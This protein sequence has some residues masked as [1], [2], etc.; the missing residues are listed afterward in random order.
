[1]HF[2]LCHSLWM[3]WCV[4]KVVYASCEVCCLCCSSI[5]CKQHISFNTFVFTTAHLRPI[6]WLAIIKHAVRNL[7]ALTNLEGAYC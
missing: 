3:Y 2:L 1:M 5:E 6:R 4:I 7:V